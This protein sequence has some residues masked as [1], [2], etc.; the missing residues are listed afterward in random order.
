MVWWHISGIYFAGDIVK[1]HLMKYRLELNALYL[2][3][4][5][6]FNIN[7]WATFCRKKL[8]FSQAIP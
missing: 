7:M 4:Y 1:M 3:D 8:L 5:E 2:F 6:L